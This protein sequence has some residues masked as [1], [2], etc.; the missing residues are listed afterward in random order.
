MG[1]TEDKVSTIHDYNEKMWSTNEESEK[2][3][4]VLI[5]GE[6]WRRW[7]YND[8]TEEF[9]KRIQLMKQQA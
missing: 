1:L 3:T 7:N 8:I 4:Y 6:E 2:E 5:I 9:Q